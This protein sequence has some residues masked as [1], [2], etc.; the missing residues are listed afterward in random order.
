MA[1]I[2]SGTA[3]I[4]FA[5]LNAPQAPATAPAGTG[6]PTDARPAIFADR[7]FLSNKG[8]NPIVV[9]PVIP[10]STEAP[11]YDYANYPGAFGASGANTQWLGFSP[12][13][14]ASAP[15]S[16]SGITVPAGAVA[17]PIE[18]V[19]IGLVLGGTNADTLAWAAY[20]SNKRA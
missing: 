14:F 2:A 7:I 4:L 5:P 18:V 1:T 8:A 13:G 20:G 11:E 6:V 12:S 3:V 15:S 16:S 17:F 9:R 19:C 10:G